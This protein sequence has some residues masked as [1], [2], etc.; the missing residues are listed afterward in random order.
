VWKEGGVSS[1]MAK[2]SRYLALVLAVA[3]AALSSCTA[4]VTPSSDEDESLKEMKRKS[5]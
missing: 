4:Y 3:I 1:A 2:H 5:L